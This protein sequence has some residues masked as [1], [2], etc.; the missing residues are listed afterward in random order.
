MKVIEF[1]TNNWDALA[2]LLTGLFGVSLHRGKKSTLSD[3]WETLLKVGWQVV[4]SLL[5]DTRITDDAWVRS[6]INEAL[7]AGLER[8]KVK[9]TPEIEEY[10][11]EAVEHVHGE[12]ARRL[13]DL[14]LDRFINVQSK[15]LDMLKTAN[16]SSP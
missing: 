3:V 7:W 15:T 8:L 6:Q 1:I 10:V 13:T 9:R 14:G 2:L 5:A 16:A 12:L 11:D 4:P